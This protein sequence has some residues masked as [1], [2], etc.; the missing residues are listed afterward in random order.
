MGSSSWVECNFLWNESLSLC[1]LLHSLKSFHLMT[2]TQESQQVFATRNQQKTNSKPLLLQPSSSPRQGNQE[3][4][5]NLRKK[6]GKT[7]KTGIGF[8]S[9]GVCFLCVCVC[10]CVFGFVFAIIW[11]MWVC[12]WE[13]NARSNGV[14][15]G[16]DVDVSD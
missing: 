3:G 2:S 13:K 15:D 9:L 10:V 7:M 11:L 6:A 8:V 14:E 5:G 12:G 16:E 1:I 4:C